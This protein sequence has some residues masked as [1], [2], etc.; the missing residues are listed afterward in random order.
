[1]VH[2]PDRLGSRTEGGASLAEVPT[3]SALPRSR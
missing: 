3:L 2:N 1:M